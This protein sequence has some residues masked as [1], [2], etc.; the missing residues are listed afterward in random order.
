MTFLFYGLIGIFATG[1]GYLLL[2]KRFRK[3]SKTRDKASGLISLEE[4]LLKTREGFWKRLK[5][6]LSEK[7]TISHSEIEKLEEALYTSDLGP[8]TVGY[9]IDKLKKKTGIEDFHWD[10]LRKT[11]KDELNSVFET[12]GAEVLKTKGDY[13]TNVWMIVGV[14][15]AGKTTSIGKLASQ[16]VGLGQK[17]LIAAGDTFRAAAD[18]QL[19]VWAQRAGAEI[20]SP[21]GLKRS[22]CPGF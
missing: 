5:N 4:A 8:K 21:Q 15:G 3:S 18:E 1:I 2:K 16:S 6:S 19:R 20:F 13:K 12:T 22:Q 7:Q 9:L 17:V 11:L 14:N 10:E